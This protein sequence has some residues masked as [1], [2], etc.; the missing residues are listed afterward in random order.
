MQRGNDG[1]K[2]PAGALILR[3]FKSS[4]GTVP[5]EAFQ[6]SAKDKQ[7]DVPRL[8]T[9]AEALCTRAQAHAITQRRYTHACSL[10]VDDVRALRPDPDDPRMRSPDVEWETALDPSSG[11]PCT[12]PGAEGHCG[13]TELDQGGLANI[14][15][16][17]K[18]L[19]RQLARLAND[20]ARATL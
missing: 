8:S 9:S 17:R 12:Q 19:Y 13:I 20:R 14:K 6:L 16:L 10:N 2:L 5:P 11:Q 4:D 1:D 7:Q 18:S 3:L 15:A